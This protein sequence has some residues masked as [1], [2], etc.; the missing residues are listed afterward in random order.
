M[1]IRNFAKLFRPESVVLIGASDRPG[2]VGT[3]VARNLRRG[4][5]KG[6]LL[7]VNPHHRTLDGMPVY[8]DV[9]SLPRPADLAV[10]ATPPDS[11]APLIAELGARGIRAAV[12]IT[13]GFGELGEGGRHLQQAALDAARPYL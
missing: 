11:V 4:G 8:R 13:A 1:S 6:E 7:L 5:F 10:V 9:A 2:A 3:V 12:I